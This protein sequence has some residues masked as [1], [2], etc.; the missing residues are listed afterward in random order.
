MPGWRL[1]VH[2]LSSFGNTSAESLDIG[3]LMAFINDAIG[4]EVPQSERIP[5]DSAYRKSAVIFA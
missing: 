5:R 2:V 1:C 4:L 3:M